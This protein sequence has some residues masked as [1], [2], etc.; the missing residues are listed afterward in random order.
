MRVPDSNRLG[1]VGYGFKVAMG[2]F[3]HTRPP[4]RPPSC[5]DDASMRSSLTSWN[6][7]RPHHRQYSPRC[8]AM[9]ISQ[10][11]AGA[12][13]LAR[14]AMDESIAYATH[15]KTMGAPIA[16]HQVELSANISANI[17]AAI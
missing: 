1:D 9:I 13:G 11:A 4:V 17:S 7:R 10:V 3:D 15:R 5:H 14:R 12:V 8:I 6:P 16:H 2:A